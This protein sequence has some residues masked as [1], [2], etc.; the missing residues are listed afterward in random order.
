MTQNSNRLCPGAKNRADELVITGA[1]IVTSSGYGDHWPV[2]RAGEEKTSAAAYSLSNFKAVPYLSDRRMLKAVSSFDAIGLAALEGLL[3]QMHFSHGLYAKERIG[4]Y[5]GAPPASTFDNEPYVEAMEASRLADG[6][7]SPSA[8]GKSC[9]SSRPVTL[10]VGLP[11]NVLCYG[12]MLLDARGPNSNYTSSALS[13]QLAVINAAKRVARGQLDLAVCGGFSAHTEP[14]HASAMRKM[15]LVRPDS[16]AAPYA[17][18]AYAQDAKASGTV[19]ADGGAFVS[20]ERRGAAEARGVRTLAKYLG[21]SI[22]SDALGPVRF[23]QEGKAL[24]ACIRNALRVS[25]VE[26]CEV[27]LIL[28]SATG[29]S[30]LDQAELTALS[31]VFL[32][33]EQL[34]ALGNT[35]RMLGN[36]IEAGGVMELALIAPLYAEGEL[37]TSMRPKA[38]V[39]FGTKIDAGKPYT[40]IVR[41]SPWGEYGCI[42]ACRED[43]KAL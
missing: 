42:V 24:E 2:F 18:E 5:V 27:G 31:R 30:A 41:V 40:L 23:D 28:Q 4:L 36:L 38:D 15:G 35:T 22:A 7:Y 32:G 20:I 26:A 9:M 29:I 16:A 14:V 17:V 37:P 8:F 33:M 34:P 6:Q 3:K 12:A 1:G 10:L 21:G 19:L 25:H 13:G 43:G 11:N 39:G